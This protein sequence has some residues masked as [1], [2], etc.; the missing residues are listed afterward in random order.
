MFIEEEQVY[1]PFNLPDPTEDERNQKHFLDFNG[2]W[3]DSKDPFLD[4]RCL[5]GCIRKLHLASVCGTI[6]ADSICLNK[7]CIC[8]G[9]VKEWAKVIIPKAD[10]KIK[11]LVPEIQENPRLNSYVQMMAKI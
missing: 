7:H 2:L 8:E 5:C 9:F 11:V 4:E 6:D 10:E 3:L 1:D